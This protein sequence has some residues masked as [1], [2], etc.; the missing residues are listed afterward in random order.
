MKQ[1]TLNRIIFLLTM[2]L[3]L[4]VV[5]SAGQTIIPRV[6]YVISTTTNKPT[7]P[8]G[9]INP[10]QSFS[11]GLG[12]AWKFKSTY[13]FQ[14]EADYVS[15]GHNFYSNK[16][17]DYN[18]DIRIIYESNYKHNY[19][20]VPL[21][22]NKYFGAGK[23]K[24]YL[25]GGGYIGFGLGGR[26]YGESGIYRGTFA[27]SYQQ[28]DGS[29]YYGPDPASINQNNRYYSHRIDLG[30]KLGIGL[31]IFDKVALDVQYDIGQV[32]VDEGQGDYK[33]RSLQFGLTVPLQ[34]GTKH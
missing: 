29:I 13:K 25:I 10:R 19:L 12:F 24:P 16:V 17:T 11:F 20:V 8:T 15:K 22:V 3:L 9:D 33:N 30:F 5:Q 32:N 27:D 28:Y 6:G 1:Y 14:I 7:S 26:F 23:L 2:Q 31:L 21:V 18:P 4:V 34:L